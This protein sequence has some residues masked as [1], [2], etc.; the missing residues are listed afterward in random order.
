M[1]S[2]T[3]HRRA[4]VDGILD[5]APNGECCRLSEVTKNLF[6]SKLSAGYRI[7]PWQRTGPWTSSI[8]NLQAKRGGSLFERCRMVLIEINITSRDTNENQMQNEV[9]TAVEGKNEQLAADLIA[10]KPKLLATISLVCASAEIRF[11]R[12]SIAAVRQR[13]GTVHCKIRGCPYR[14]QDFFSGF[15]FNQPLGSYK[16]K[17]IYSLWWADIYLK[18]F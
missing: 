6:V 18:H 9:Q 7:F 16:P 15:Y 1:F 2:E 8:I 11:W 14:L 12:V 10:S 3:K 13:K 5:S 17:T 4:M